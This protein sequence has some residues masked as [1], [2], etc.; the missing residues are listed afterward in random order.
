LGGGLRVDNTLRHKP[1]F[2]LLKGCSV[3]IRNRNQGICHK[4]A[5]ALLVGL[6]E[7]AYLA[8][9]HLIVLGKFL[10]LGIRGQEIINR[11]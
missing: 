2:D 9:V 11:A 1:L 6:V 10:R 7:C 4:L 8:L 3:T 5:L